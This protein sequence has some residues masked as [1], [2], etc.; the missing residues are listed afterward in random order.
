MTL[1]LLDEFPVSF[2]K[3]SESDTFNMIHKIP[4][5]PHVYS[6]TSTKFPFFYMED[7]GS[8]PIIDISS[9]CGRL[10]RIQSGL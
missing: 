9:D 8:N 3:K 10:V 1:C 4:Q 6:N 5:N 7:M 2:I